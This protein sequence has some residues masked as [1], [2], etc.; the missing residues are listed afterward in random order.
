MKI[1]RIKVSDTASELYNKFLDKY[2]DEYY[3]LEGKQKEELSFKF[4]PINLRIK[5]YDYNQF[6]KEI[7]DDGFDADDSDKFIDISCHH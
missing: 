4:M 6:Y 5:W 1:Q 7:S 3:D 2:F